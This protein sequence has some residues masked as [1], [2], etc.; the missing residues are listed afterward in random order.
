[1]T[2]ARALAGAPAVDVILAKGI[3]SASEAWDHGR[4]L[5]LAL[6]ATGRWGAVEVR[7]NDNSRSVVRYQGNAAALR[8]SVH[9]QLVACTSDLVEMI[10]QRSDAAWRRMQARL[11]A[12]PAPVRDSA[13]EPKGAVHDLAA[14]LVAQQPHLARPATP[15]IGWGRFAAR[16]PARTL[17]LGSCT[18]GTNP[19]IRIHPV[20]DHADVP[21]W[22]VGFVVFHELL[23]VVVPPVMVGT[24][25][26]VHGKAFLRAERVHPDFHRANAWEVAN[27]RALL[28]RAREQAG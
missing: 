7:V 20:L 12:E 14:L 27:I 2:A 11:A 18:G 16:G 3:P 9:W 6:L 24:R 28:R 22:F 1:M 8:V 10:H 4:Q 5:G 17:R 25:R 13:L 26:M 21:D 15:P 19:V 23:H